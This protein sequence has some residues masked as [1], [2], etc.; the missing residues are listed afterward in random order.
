MPHTPGTAPQQ[1][2]LH[3]LVGAG[4]RS[5]HWPRV[6]LFW[7]ALL[8]SAVAMTLVQTLLSRSGPPLWFYALYFISNTA[9]ALTALLA[10]RWFQ[11]PWVAAVMAPVLYTVAMLPLRIWQVVQAPEQVRTM[12]AG[13]FLLFGLLGNM[14]LFCGLLLFL[15]VLPGLFLALAAASVLSGIVSDLLAAMLAAARGVGFSARGLLEPLAFDIGG[16]LLFAGVYWAGTLLPVMRL[17][18]RAASA[19]PAPVGALADLQ[20]AADFRTVRRALRPASI[21]SI[22]FGII[23]VVIGINTLEDNSINAFLILL[24]LFLLGEGIWILVQPTPIGMLVDGFALCLLGAWNLLVTFL[25][26][27]AGATGP[28]GFAILGL[29][30]IGL[31][32]QSFRRYGR[33]AGS[34]QGAVSAEAIKR[35][36]ELVAGITQMSMNT[37]VDVIEF[38][39]GAQPWK[40]RLR[41]DLGVFVAGAEEDVV[42]AAKSEVA[43]VPEEAMG[44][45]AFK[46]TFRLGGHTYTGTLSPEAYR[47]YEAW[48]TARGAFGA[49]AG[50][51]S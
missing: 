49:A 32:I 3:E 5:I 8:L 26:V 34:G 38:S 9:L 27:Q 33:F 47:R 29:F 51:G 24:G 48:H 19:V 37:A 31:G 4:G 44:D 39:V 14:L 10:C 42:L 45:K 25:N 43:I 28:R 36:D 11:N 23:A 46:A 1:E 13:N 30:Q 40:A 18:E 35:V 15:R 12:L 22:I 2:T 17:P 16:G 41:D 6:G 20:R 50:L 7:M 21:G